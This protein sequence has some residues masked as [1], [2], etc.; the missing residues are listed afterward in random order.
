MT[1]RVTLFTKPGCHLCEAVEQVIGRVR[2]KTPFELEVR[3]ILDD[4]RDLEQFQHDIPVVH[5][6]G[7]EIARH[8]MSAAQLEAALGRE[9]PGGEE[10]R[11]IS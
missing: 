3:N 9:S 1:H 11:A 8:R 4:A 5:V 7:Q 2:K 10:H 6:D